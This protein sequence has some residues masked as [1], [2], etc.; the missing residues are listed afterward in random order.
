MFMFSFLV[1][2]KYSFLPTTKSFILLL[3]LAASSIQSHIQPLIFLPQWGS[4]QT[5][6]QYEFEDLRVEIGCSGS[7][8]ALSFHIERCIYALLSVKGQ[9][10]PLL[11]RL[12]GSCLK[13]TMSVF[14]FKG[15]PS[16][17]FLNK[18]FIPYSDYSH[19][20]RC[21]NDHMVDW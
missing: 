2:F 1:V 12:V 10:C 16:L 17:G 9:K 20:R 6:N 7:Q 3:L 13:R 21:P 4:G 11:T 14:L 19:H 5:I 15:F 18:Y 8:S